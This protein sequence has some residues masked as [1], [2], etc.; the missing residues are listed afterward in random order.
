M[1]KHTKERRGRNSL[2]ALSNSPYPELKDKFKF[3]KY[4][5]KDERGTENSP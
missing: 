1:G 5:C 3:K 2:F 4:I